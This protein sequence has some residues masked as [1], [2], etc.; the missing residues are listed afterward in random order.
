MEVLVR[1]DIQFPRCSQDFRTYMAIIYPL[2]SCGGLCRRRGISIGISR[3]LYITC[4]GWQNEVSEEK[5]SYA[6]K[7]SKDQRENKKRQSSIKNNLAYNNN[8]YII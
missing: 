4:C 1:L 8:P 7:T 2:R 3:G 5:E 6:A